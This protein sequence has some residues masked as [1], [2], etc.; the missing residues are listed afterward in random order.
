MKHHRRGR[1][2]H[3]VQVGWHGPLGTPDFPC[4]RIGVRWLTPCVKRTLC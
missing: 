3:D 2:G 1:V 4:K